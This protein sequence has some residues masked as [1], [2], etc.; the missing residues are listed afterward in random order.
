MYANFL[1]KL[2][3]TTLE[4]RDGHLRCIHSFD[5]ELQNHEMRIELGEKVECTNLALVSFTELPEATGEGTLGYSWSWKDDSDGVGYPGYL[6]LHFTINS[7]VSDFI[8]KQVQQNNQLYIGVEEVAALSER[9]RQIGSDDCGEYI[10]E[11]D[12]R[13]LP[14]LRLDRVIPIT[15]A[16]KGEKRLDE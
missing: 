5:G 8:E 2:P 6:E 10:W 15:N 3:R 11:I 16:N 13:P 9:L 4:T 1:L 7:F 12:K 14:V